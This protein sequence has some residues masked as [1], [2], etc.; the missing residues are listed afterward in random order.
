MDPELDKRLRNIEYSL[1][2][3]R[4]LLRKIR[5]VQRNA[6]LFRLFYWLII[7]GITF[8]AFYYLQPYIKQVQSI[9][10]GYNDALKINTPEFT[11]FQ[12]LINQIK[13]E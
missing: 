11:H 9:Y 6:G 2:E 4:E 3:N 13:G 12:D 1:K 5:R 7:I 10:T 8:G